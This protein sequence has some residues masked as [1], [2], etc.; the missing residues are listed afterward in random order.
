[1]KRIDIVLEA[2]EPKRWWHYLGVKRK[3]VRYEGGVSFTEPN[4]L[5][6]GT[7]I[8]RNGTIRNIKIKEIDNEE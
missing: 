7:P 8:N 5:F 4:Q 1:M 3:P 6:I 2:L